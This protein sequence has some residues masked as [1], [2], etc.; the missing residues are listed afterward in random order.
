VELPILPL[1]GLRLEDNQATDIV[2]RF[3]DN[4]HQGPLERVTTG[5]V[6]LTY[7]IPTFT[8]FP[9]G[10]VRTAVSVIEN[11][12]FTKHV[13]L[14]FLQVSSVDELHLAT[15]IQIKE[16]VIGRPSWQEYDSYIFDDQ[17]LWCIGY[18]HES[19]LLLSGV[20]PD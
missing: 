13:S 17:F 9:K 3:R 8:V 12:L 5:I 1:P 20:W 16:F 15:P 14:Y 19:Q 7:R 4:F 18:T 10:S 2:K 6:K 11:P